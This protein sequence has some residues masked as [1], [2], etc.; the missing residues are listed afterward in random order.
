M[1]A[2]LF[3][4]NGKPGFPFRRGGYF[5]TAASPTS[6]SAETLLSAL[7]VPKKS[8]FLTMYHGSSTARALS[9]VPCDIKGVPRWCDR[10]GQYGIKVSFWASGTLKIVI[11]VKNYPQ[12]RCFRLADYH[13]LWGWGVLISGQYM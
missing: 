1:M 6:A 10:F 9:P 3:S 4:R 2:T 8:A 12:K 5:F 11:Y 13:P 7:P